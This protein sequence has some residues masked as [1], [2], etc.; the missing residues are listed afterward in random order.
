MSGQAL[1][2]LLCG[3][4]HVN[5]ESGMRLQ[6]QVSPQRLVYL[7]ENWYLDAWCQLLEGLRSFAIDAIE[8][9]AVMIEPA[10]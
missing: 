7:Q 6:G 10:L 5:R 4:F 1:S 2:R 8:D 3:V 9:L